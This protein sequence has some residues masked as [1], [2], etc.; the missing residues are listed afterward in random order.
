MSWLDELVFATQEIDDRVR[1]A[2]W[3]RGASDA[4]IALYRIGHLHRKLPTGIEYPEDFLEWSWKGKKLEDCYVLPL[5][6]TL[7][8]VKGVQF[9]SVD[10][11][12]KNY[13]DYFLAAD[14]PILFGLHEA[15][16][17]VWESKAIWTVEG[18]FDLFPLQ[19]FRPNVVATLTARITDQFIRLLRRLVEDVYLAY[20]MDER[21][22]QAI[23]KFQKYHGREFRA[24]EIQYPRIL[25]ADG[26][27]A[28]DLG[29]LWESGGD[30]RIKAILSVY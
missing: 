9:R 1:E 19:R 12:K 22:R 6:T 26:K 10:R 25:M 16:P 17:H 8:Q 15:M 5:T 14:E 30:A 20:D 29:D 24:H 23:Q 2:L 4:Q 21:G 13:C 11:A 28:K 18:A 27:T 7:G 3:S